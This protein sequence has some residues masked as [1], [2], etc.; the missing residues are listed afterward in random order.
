MKQSIKLAVIFVLAYTT[1][2][3]AQWSFKNKIKGNGKVVTEKRN[4]VSYDEI[5]VSGFFDVNL[6]A[7]E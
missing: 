6:V 3:Q 4:T 2:A 1:V 7:G 5:M